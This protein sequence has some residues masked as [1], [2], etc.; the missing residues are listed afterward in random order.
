MWPF[1]KKQAPSP[2]PEP[3]PEAAEPTSAGTNRT[4][5]DVLR[6]LEADPAPQR[7][8]PRPIEV[9]PEPVD[10][11]LGQALLAEG[12]VTREFLDRQVTIAGQ[13]DSYLGRVL[14]GTPAPTEAQLLAVLAAGSRVPEID[15]K[16]CKVHVATAR[17]I[18]REIAIKYKMVP[19]DRIGELVCVVFA[20]E[21]NPKGIEAIRRE[22]QA[23]VKALRCPPHHLQIL[24]RRLYAKPA[25][26]AT[27]AGAVS[28]EPISKHEFDEGSG[29]PAAK[30]EAHWEALYATAGPIRAGR[31]GRR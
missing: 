1:R 6:Q 7:R 16:Q 12:P 23:H 24:L 28:A 8:R 11:L 13:G 22:T 19:I 26:A 15:L 10:P 3:R 9:P 14:A 27:S 2:E 18:P 21:P 20:G 17:S 25:D 31:I 4:A 29:G 30:I 5:D